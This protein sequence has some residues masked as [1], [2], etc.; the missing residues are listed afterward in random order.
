M[1][2][3]RL[4]LALIIAV[5]GVNSLLAND[6]LLK[7]V[8]QYEAV[9]LGKTTVLIE[10][11][12]G[13]S[14]LLSIRDD[15]QVSFARLDVKA[16]KNDLVNSK[17]ISLPLGQSLSQIRALDDLDA[18]EEGRPYQGR[19]FDRDDPKELTQSLGLQHSVVD[20]EF[21]STMIKQNLDS[22]GFQSVSSDQFRLTLESGTM[23][24]IGLDDIGRVIRLESEVDDT[25]QGASRS[26]RK[27]RI[28][29]VVQVTYDGEGTNL[30]S[31]FKMTLGDQPSYTLRLESSVD[32]SGELTDR[33]HLPGIEITDG[34][35]VLV[36]DHE[37]DS[38]VLLDGRIVTV[39]D[40]QVVAD[41]QAARQ[42]NSRG[43]WLVWYTVAGFII[44]AAG[45]LLLWLRKAK[46]T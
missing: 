8:E 44:V 20:T 33:L 35:P 37:N 43:A 5:S 2:S 30:P 42:A 26:A 25:S 7:A 32:V 18:N 31:R 1:S 46:G 10:D 12:S 11:E 34:V 45:G 3:A 40:S 28:K 4:F 29:T 27:S 9:W 16:G 15:R 41:A 39:V 38:H 13:T 6:R 19:F 24:E 21:L 23:V 36:A 22:D 14:M 17:Y